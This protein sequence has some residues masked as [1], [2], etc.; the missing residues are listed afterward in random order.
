MSNSSE[1]AIAAATPNSNLRRG[2]PGTTQIVANRDWGDA[3]VVSTQNAFYYTPQITTGLAT[4]MG[5]LNVPASAVKKETVV[6]GRIGAGLYFRYVKRKLTKLQDKKLAA[7]L[8]KLLAIQL[9]AEATGQQAL[10]EAIESELLTTAREQVLVTKGFDT[11]VSRSV[12]GKFMSR[13]ENVFI[14]KLENFPRPLPA[15]VKR[16]LE[17]ARALQ[18]F[19]GFEILHLDHTKDKPLKTAA[20]KVRQ[21][22][23]ILF[24]TMVTAPNNLYFITDWVDDYCDLTLDKLRDLYNPDGA[25]REVLDSHILDMAKPD[26]LSALT[27]RVQK[28]LNIL[29]DTNA[30]NWQ[31]Q[32]RIAR[33]DANRLALLR[34]APSSFWRRIINRVW[35]TVETEAK[36]K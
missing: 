29:R 35:A 2:A 19:D 15:P 25:D 33:S 23:P 34:S 6:Q 7:R 30:S 12:V 32:E 14:K 18:V 8:R 1:A 3:Y 16:K 28:R 21:K 4:P 22:D 17:Q 10:L 31:E 24:G 5:S 26:S 11:V 9:N 20:E 27:E 13:V 36:K